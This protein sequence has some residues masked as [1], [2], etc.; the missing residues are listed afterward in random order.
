MPSLPWIKWFASKWLSSSAR[1]EMSLPARAIYL[2]L[3]FQIYEYGGA[4]S[5]E[6][7]QLCKLTMTTPEEFDSAWPEIERHIVP[8]DSDPTRLTNVTAKHYLDKLTGEHEAAVEAG[9]RG[10]RPKKGQAKGQAKG[11]DNHV[12]VD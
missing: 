4:I 2:D 8:L 12:D 10:G 3:L 6:R 9:R 7:K 1:V 5:S 11:G